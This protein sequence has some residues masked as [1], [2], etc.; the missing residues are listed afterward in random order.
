MYE[1]GA[2]SYFLDRD[3]VL[4]RLP[5]PWQLTTNVIRSNILFFFALIS[6]RGMSASLQVL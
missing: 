2:G 5:K 6:H 4:L 1:N 3:Y